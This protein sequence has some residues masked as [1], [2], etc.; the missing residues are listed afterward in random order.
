MFC[1]LTHFYRTERTEDSSFG[2][3]FPRR[4]DS[5]K[6]FAIKSFHQRGL[7]SKVLSA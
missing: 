1:I 3:V 5:A 2:G 4:H 7:H 6:S